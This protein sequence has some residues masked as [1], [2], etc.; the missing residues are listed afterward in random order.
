MSSVQDVRFSAE[1]IEMGRNFANKIWNASRLVLQG[2]HPE[3]APRVERATL[4]DRWIFSRLAAVTQ[5]VAGLYERYEF[6][7]VARVLYRFVWNEVCDWYLE[8]SKTRLYSDDEM[9]RFQVSGNLL[10]LLEQ[11]MPLLHPVM[12]FITEEVYGS[13]PWVAAGWRPN[14]LFEARYPK[15]EPEWVDPDA[16]KAM[17]A[18]M[19]VVG[20]LRSTRE[21]LGLGRDVIG[22]VRVLESEPGAA[23]GLQDLRQ[24]F[25]QLCWCELT[26]VIV[27]GAVPTGRYASVNASGVKAFLDIEGLVDVER[28]RA[29]LLSKAQKAQ[30]EASKAQ[31]KLDNQGF[32]AK[33]PEAVVAEERERLATA[34]AALTEA[35]LQYRERI[36]EELPSTEG[37]RR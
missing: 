18:F 12:P 29:R 26:E 4:A 8:V 5:E 6:D 27:D 37:K 2:A 22:S 31:A 3:A 33:A 11:V 32:L 21:E 34:E 24:A 20:G 17:E 28:E 19:A 23:A 25:R 16:E 15:A 1:R 30:G 10:V 7:D 9:E 36:G 35:R 13:I 14:T